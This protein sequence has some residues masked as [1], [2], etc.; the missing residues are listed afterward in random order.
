MKFCANQQHIFHQG[1]MA[2][3]NKSVITFFAMKFE[4]F[5]GLPFEDYG[6]I[7]VVSI[8]NF[9]LSEFIAI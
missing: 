9:L 3:R 1:I 8:S 2:F 5:K 4:L 6:I 7:S